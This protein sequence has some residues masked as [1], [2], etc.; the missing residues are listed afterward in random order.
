M[1][2]VSNKALSVGFWGTIQHPFSPRAV[3]AS[4]LYPLCFITHT[5]CFNYYLLL[6]ISLVVGGS[7]VKFEVAVIEKVHFL[8]C[9][10]KE[11]Y[12]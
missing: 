3:W 5:A 6:K 9:S 7:E 8:Q 12:H 2:C 4:S 10:L 1:C 11:T